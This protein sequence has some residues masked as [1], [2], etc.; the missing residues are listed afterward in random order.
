MGVCASLLFQGLSATLAS[1]RCALV[2]AQLAITGMFALNTRS[3]QFC[4]LLASG[5][6]VSAN[7][8]LF[9]WGTIIIKIAWIRTAWDCS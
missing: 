9:T 5:R 2:G 3:E 8:S 1:E 7:V 6:L 4:C